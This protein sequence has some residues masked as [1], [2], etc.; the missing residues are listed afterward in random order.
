MEDFLAFVDEIGRTVDGEYIYRFDF[1]TDLETVW[2]DFFNIAPAVIVP[3]LQP[4]KNCLS[5]SAKVTFPRQMVIA[6]KNYCY[7][8]QDCID[9]ILPMIFSEIDDDTLEFDEKPFFLKF[10][11]SLS[12]IEEIFKQIGLELFEMEEVERGDETPIDDFIDSISD[13]NDDDFDDDIW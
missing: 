1:T 13:N 3:D 7:S 11:T 5:K 4:D 12:K 9:G 8:M 10:G 6:K 2:G